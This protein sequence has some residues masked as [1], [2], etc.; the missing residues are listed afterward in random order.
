MEMELLL[1][2]CC[3]P[4]LSRRD[5]NS[6]D[7]MDSSNVTI[8]GNKQDGHKRKS[9]ENII[10]VDQ[11]LR[12][13]FSSLFSGDM[14]EETCSVEERKPKNVY[15]YKLKPSKIPVHYECIFMPDLD[16]D[17]DINLQTNIQLP[18]KTECENDKSGI[19][20][21]DSNL[22]R[23]GYTGNSEFSNIPSDPQKG[24]DGTLRCAEDK[25]YF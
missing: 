14:C 5:S 21:E 3:H 19:E 13:V 22:V 1:Q 11:C 24:N 8:N 7:K 16:T 17:D 12:K 2:D 4:V 10:R 9:P 6:C 23:L 25:V 18:I 20:F 15:M